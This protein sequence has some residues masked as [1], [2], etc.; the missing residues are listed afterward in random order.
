MLENWLQERAF[1]ILHEVAGR[2]SITSL[3]AGLDTCG[4]YF[5][6]FSNNEYYVG[7]AKNVTRRYLQHRKTHL[8]IIRI[9]FK[10]VAAESLKQAESSD[11]DFFKS[12]VRLRNIDEMEDLIMER[13][14]D[15]LVPTDFA[16]H[17]LNDFEYNELTGIKYQNDELQTNYK[18]RRNFQLLSSQR[19]YSE[20]LT[21]CQAY[22]QFC[23]PAPLQT[24]YA[25]WSVTC[26]E[27]KPD[28]LL[29]RLNIYQ[30]E[31]FTVYSMPSDASE[32]ALEYV[33]HLAKSPL[34]TSDTSK[35]G[36]ELIHQSCRSVE[37]SPR[38]YRTG[39][40]D[41]MRL[42]VLDYDLL[43]LFQQPS[44]IKATRL[45]NLRLMRKGTNMNSVAH[46]M[47][48]AKA[49]LTPFMSSL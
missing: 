8:D 10:P 14:F 9:S 3:F 12:R 35:T 44:F 17:F 23:V 41:Q 16:N 49:M 7:L 32:A 4:I 25:F 31:V 2:K 21:A 11:I 1:H 15:K 22:V 13:D 27:A 47:G 28:S 19:F 26:F 42:S 39:G 40:K 48:L 29:I 45:H 5:L 24:E 6:H 37:F 43:S 34:V 46:C 38:F 33:F 36:R 20:L 30:Q 18:Y